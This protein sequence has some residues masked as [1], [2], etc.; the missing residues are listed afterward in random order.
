[1]KKITLFFVFVAAVAFSNAQVLLYEDF[2]SGDMPPDD[3]TISSNEENWSVVSSANAGG[4]APEAMF[5]WTPQ[6]SGQSF[7]ISPYLDLSNNTS[8]MLR[9][10]FMHALDHYGGPYTIGAAVRAQDGAWETVWEA[11]NPSGNFDSQEISLVLENDI[12]T[13]DDFQFA[14][15]FSGNSYN[16]N[17]WYIDD[18]K[19][20]MPLNF[21]L[22]LTGVDVP[23]MIDGATPVIGKI[24]NTGSEVIHSFDL[25]WQLD[26]GEVYTT[27]FDGLDLAFGAHFAFESEHCMRLNPDL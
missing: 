23:D 13:S 15:Y 8:G 9:I 21:D 14:L 19:V 22:A 16:L 1:M 7:L 12:V 2:I 20:M 27:S 6:F 17:Y 4:E 10:S 26:D 18:I 5:S 3:W 24:T 11:V 25:N